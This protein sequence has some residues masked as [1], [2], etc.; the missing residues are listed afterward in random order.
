MCRETGN[1][2]KK[3]KKPRK[4]Q[5]KKTNNKLTTD[6]SQDGTS[7]RMHFEMEYDNCVRHSYY[8]FFLTT[9]PLSPS[10]DAIF[11]FMVFFFLLL[12]FTFPRLL[13]LFDG[14]NKLGEGEE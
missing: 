4:Q 6:V 11:I 5:Q 9:M 7:E 14:L 13:S 1:G 2:K 3:Q 10:L 12:F 8:F